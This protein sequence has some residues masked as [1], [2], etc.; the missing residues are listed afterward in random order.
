MHHPQQA[1]ITAEFLVEGAGAAVV[2]R[3]WPDG[4]DF[5]SSPVYVQFRGEK[6]A[7]LEQLG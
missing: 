6:R 2:Q 3:T 7:G 4:A 5:A 1:Q